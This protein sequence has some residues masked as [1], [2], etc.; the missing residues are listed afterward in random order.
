[1]STFVLVHGAWHG[2]WCWQKLTPVLE[3]AGHRVLTPDLPGRGPEA[4]GLSGLTLDDY[5]DF[6]SFTL[7]AESEPVIL[8]GHSLGG[9]VITQAA[10]FCSS[11]VGLLV[12]LAA[13][14]P[15]DG[16]SVAEWALND[17]DS[18]LGK[19]MEVD[20]NGGAL[21]LDAAGSIEC[22][23]EDCSTVDQAYAIS[24]LSDEPLAPVA[25]PLCLSAGWGDRLPAVYVECL[26]D[27]AVS[28]YMQRQMQQKRSFRDVRSLDSGHSPFFSQ[29]RQLANL[30]ESAAEHS[31]MPGLP[32][33]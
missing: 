33:M 32:F 21:R 20:W 5:A 28:P 2:G 1:M 19:Y 18:L 8:V 11:D 13:Y 25:Q 27:Q 7:A 9:A 22:L 30:L 12:Y 10:E 16:E 23:Y 3:A 31:K 24:H 17:V 6:L 14:I 15:S 4:K 29:P 26:R